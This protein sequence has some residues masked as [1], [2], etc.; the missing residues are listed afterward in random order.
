MH[1]TTEQAEGSESSLLSVGP[2]GWKS[3]A[4][5]ACLNH[6]AELSV[7]VQRALVSVV[8]NLVKFVLVFILISNLCRPLRRKMK[9]LKRSGRIWSRYC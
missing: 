4:C 2:S 1:A 8:L 3:S 6:L 9:R 5:L 7:L